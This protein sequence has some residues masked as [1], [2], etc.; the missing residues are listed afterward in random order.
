[1]INTTA[2]STAFKELLEGTIG[3][4]RTLK[5]SEYLSVN[6][7]AFDEWTPTGCTVTPNAGYGPSGEYTADSVAV[8]PTDYLEVNLDTIADNTVVNASVYAWTAS[9]ITQ[10]YIAITCKDASVSQVGPLDI[11]TTKQ[12]FS[13]SDVDILS[14]ATQPIISIVFGSGSGTVYLAEC[15]VTD[16][17]HLFSKNQQ[18]SPS[19]LSSATEPIGGLLL[20]NTTYEITFGKAAKHSASPVSAIGSHKIEEISVTINLHHDLASNIQETARTEIRNRVLYTGDRIKQALAFPDNLSTTAGSTATGIISGMLLDLE[21]AISK[22][23]WES[24]P[25]RIESQITGRMLVHITQPTS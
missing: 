1:M 6:S 17:D 9:G 22:E 2:I 5:T 21:H 25:P 4:V 13:I 8:T 12:K 10:L 15:H 7:N 14:G 20:L 24:N 11:T 16:D 18:W 3:S 23:D 19:V